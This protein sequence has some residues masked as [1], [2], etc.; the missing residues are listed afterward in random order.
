MENPQRNDQIDESRVVEWI[1]T[2]DEIIPQRD[3]S[4]TYRY[5]AF[6]HATVEAAMH[7]LSKL[8]AE[9]FLTKYVVEN[10]ASCPRCEHSDFDVS[11]ICPFSKHRAIEQGLTIGHASCG[12]KDFESKFGLG[13]D[14][15]CPSCHHSFKRSGNDYQKHEMMYRCSGCERLFTT[16]MVQLLCRNCGRTMSYDR[17][18]LRPIY[19]FRVN[20]TL[21]ARP[22]TTEITRYLKENGFEVIGPASLRG[23][24]NVEHYFD[25]LVKKNRTNFVIDVISRS[26]NVSVD[27]VSRFFLKIIDAKPPR[28]FLIALGELDHEAEK[29]VALYEQSFRTICSKQ[30]IAIFE[31]LS[32]LLGL[33]PARSKKLEAAEAVLPRISQVKPEHDQAEQSLRK[34]R[35]LTRRIIDETQ[36]SLSG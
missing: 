9:G 14:L 27:D 31:R 26:G 20:Q 19:G 21:R 16:P 29:L 4:G 10:V 12:Y 13:D 17:A 7:I 15:T 32:A 2:Q 28:A 18:N 23:A 5:P 3:S 34:A 36:K 8:E 33:P 30:P 6:A 11:Y 25:L 35:A 22:L 24:T 1:L